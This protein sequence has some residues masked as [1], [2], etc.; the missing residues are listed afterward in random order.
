MEAPFIP[1]DLQPIIDFH[2]HLC[3]GL[4]IGYRAAKAGMKQI[5][6][7]RSEDEEL[8]T[9]VENNSCAVDAIQVM[10]GCTFGKGN[11]FFKDYGKHVYTLAI[12]PDGRGVR[13]SL[14]NDAF[15]EEDR[16]ERIKHLLDL[17]E[18]QLFDIEDVTIELPQQA[19]IHNSVACHNC[20]EPVMETRIKEKNKEV[21]CIPCFN[22]KFQ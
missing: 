4:V 16:E 3:P 9:I 17:D 18:Q 10:T 8:V 21:Y 19:Q 13:I 1:D 12:R 7:M 20:G 15:R 22:Q 11:F 2:G 5:H 14:K 6:A